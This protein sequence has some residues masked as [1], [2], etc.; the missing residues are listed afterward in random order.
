MTDGMVVTN[1]DRAKAIN[2]IQ[3]SFPILTDEQLLN[4]A[5]YVNLHLTIARSLDVIESFKKTVNGGQ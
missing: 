4:V 2:T 1:G 5:S 3:S